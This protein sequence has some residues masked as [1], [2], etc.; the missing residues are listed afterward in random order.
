MPRTA[1]K[2]SK[3][4]ITPEDLN[5]FTLL[6][7]PQV[8]PNGKEI[9]F[10]HKRIGDKNNYVTNLWK[11]PVAG[12]DAVAF[13]GGDKDSMGL[14]SPQGD[15]IAFVRGSDKGPQIYVIPVGGG[16]ARRLT[17][18]PEGSIAAFEWSPNG[19]HLAVAFRETDPDWTK[20]AVEERKKKGLTDAPRVLDDLW[21]RLDGD[22]YF[23]GQ[24]FALYRVDLEDGSHH[25][26][27]DKDR[28]GFFTFAW[29]PN[30]KT[31]AV[32]ANTSVR[33]LFS[34][35]RGAIYLV[36]AQSGKAS[37]VENLPDGPKTNVAWSPDG[38]RLAYAGREGEEDIYSTENL[39]LFVCNARGGGA[40]NLTGGEDYCLMA[41]CLADTG[42]VPFGPNFQWAPD[43]KRL[44]VSIGWHGES[45]VAAV[46]STG[47]K[48]KFL[49]RGVYDHVMGNISKDGKVLAL[50]RATTT[51]L[52]EIYAGMVSATAIKTKALTRFNHELL[53]QL[54]PIKAESHWIKAA[55]GHKVQVWSLIP[56]KPGKLPAVLEIHGGPHAQYGVGFFHEFQVL[57]AQGYAVFYSNPRGSKGYGQ[58]HCAAI[59]GSWGGADWVDVQAVTQFMRE[60]PRVNPKK[61]G[62]MGGSY[63]GYMTNWVIGHTNEFAGAI[64]DRCVSN[65]MSM[66]GSSDFPIS[67][68]M[69]WEGN[70]WDRPEQL[71][72]QSP[73]KYMGNCTTPTLIIHSEG[74]LRCNIEQS[75]QVHTVLTWKKVPCRFVRYPRTTSHG[76][77]RGGPP[78]MRLHRLHQ[79]ID[80]W[81]K[82]LR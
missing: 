68:D 54:N 37:K 14:W 26:L 52:P 66:G 16:E 12:G 82:Y 53:S 46:P 23:N 81:K 57:A 72:E 58:A 17:Q 36:D 39:D 35:Q 6:G 9:L 4:G 69:Y 45:H 62:V 49:T 59:K 77:S 13:T 28:L 5:E 76:M 47:G 41:V 56:D 18:F 24:R 21:Y 79:I 38:K 1:S 51:T 43:G 31:L 8:S 15:Q 75:E 73:I 2:A 44:L 27:Y 10:V 25:K 32:T 70:F 30:S 65:L 48:L 7:G 50:M 61:M 33:A 78:D 80:W 40:K 55:D 63:G 60:H 64:T 11:V 74:D 3:R 71:W 67:P 29:S 34:S 20:D 42:E 19:K 22:G